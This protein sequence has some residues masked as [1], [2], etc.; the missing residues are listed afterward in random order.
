MRQPILLAG[1]AAMGAALLINAPVSGQGS[2]PGS[3]FVAFRVD[4]HRVIATLKVMEPSARQ[5]ADG[6]SAEPMA[7]FGYR[8]FDPPAPWREQG[9][10]GM[11]AGD[12]WRIHTAPG[13]IFQA[14][15]ERIVGGNARCNNAI[16]VLL[17]VVPEESNAFTGL[18][19]RYF[20]AERSMTL[21]P[22]KADT[23]SAVGAAPSPST[24]EFRRA[25]ESTLNAL[26][27]RELPQVLAD[28]AP[29][30]ARMAS[31]PVAYHRSWARQQQAVNEAM[32]AGRGRMT[33]DIQSFGLAPDG[34]PLHFVRA[35]W[36]VRRRQ[37]FAASLWLRGEQRVEVIQTNLRPA[38]WLRSFEFQNRV[39]REHLG[40][41]LN[42]FDWDHDG[43]GEVLLA[44]G[45]Y[46]SMRISLLEYSP[47]G[48]QPT[49]IEYAY[50]C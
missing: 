42:S 23:G 43:W 44:Q 45:G 4:T 30:L 21:Q 46:E 10:A 50:G 37:G 2:E 22:S 1:V 48:L 17:R 9:A 8:Y 40:L 29:S 24:A 20:L 7:R 39:G 12:R 14:E 11:R 15:T 33:Y 47:T 13:Q 32:Q 41:V 26:L 27:A 36:A 31:S 5:V 25:L 49:G 3:A 35:E 16:G 6:M 38:S 34:M 19:A 28:T 18:P